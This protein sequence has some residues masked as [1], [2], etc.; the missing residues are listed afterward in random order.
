MTTLRPY[1]DQAVAAIEHA[2]C[3]GYDVLFVLPTGGGKTEIAKKVAENAVACG[4]RVLI[5]THRREILFQTSRTFC[6]DQIGLIKAGLSIDLNCP[7]QIASIQTLWMRCLRTNKLPLPA[8]D[9]IIIDEAHHIRAKTWS[10]ILEAYPNARRLGLTATPCRGDGRGL[11]NYFNKLI[12]G[13]QIPDLIKEKY[14]IP[15]IYFAPVDP[16]LKGVGTSQGDYVLEQLATRVDRPDLVG[17]IISDWSK[18]GENRKTIIFAV[19]VGHS[20]HIRDEFAK[21]GIKAEHIDGSTPKPERDA[22]LERLKSGDTEIV[23]NCNV[24]T[25]GFDAPQVSCIVLARP[26]K[27]LGLFRQM[28]GRGLRPCEGKSNLRLLDHSGAVF[29]HGALEDPV[30]WELA[31]DRRAENKVHA[32]LSKAEQRNRFVD[33]SQCGA[34]RTR[35]EV[36]PNC[37][38]LPQRRAAAISFRDG[39]LAQV[40]AG[41]RNASS[42][43]REERD[44]W[45]RELTFICQ[46]RGY[47]PGWA[48]HKYKTK[49]GV[50]PRYGVLVEPIPA[51]VEVLAWVRSR[52]IAFAKARGSAA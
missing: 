51:S 15:T 13:P 46:K 21:A 36:C 35:G 41:G 24:L 16:D 49:F 14:L 32:S 42:Y 10:R 25:E 22:V 17:N 26:T 37:G 23:C 52:D 1:Q 38:F 48:A 34:L 27:Q 18:H 28:A 44:R 20:R 11:G 33:C 45:M 19:N 4:Q 30:I 8:A 6:W 12:D 7:I 2:I 29:R 50:W 40:N 9:L 43:S 31:E 47:K 3:D 39:E 5:L